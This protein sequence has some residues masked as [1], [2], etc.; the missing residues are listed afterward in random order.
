MEGNLPKSELLWA[1]VRQPRGSLVAL[2]TLAAAARVDL[3]ALSGLA[4]QLSREKLV[5]VGVCS[6]T[7]AGGSTPERA[8]SSP[9]LGERCLRTPGVSGASRAGDSGLYSICGGPGCEASPTRMPAHPQSFRSRCPK[10]THLAFTERPSSACEP[11]G[12]IT[13][14]PSPV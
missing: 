9:K 10:S 6:T 4:L 5:P 3:G 14:A 7:K 11:L 12:R 8:E 1:L 2:R 13:C